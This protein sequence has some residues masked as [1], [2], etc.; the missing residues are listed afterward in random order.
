M[1]CTY[2]I[3]EI[4]S[5]VGGELQVSGISPEYPISGIFT[6]SRS[7][8]QT[9]N[10]LFIALRGARNDGHLFVPGLAE[11]GV[12][13]FLISSFSGSFPSESVAFIHVQDTLEALQRLAAFHRLRFS[14]PVIGITGSNGK[15]VI[16]EWLH[17]LLSEQFDIVRSPRSYNSQVGV[18]LSVWLMQPE[19]NLA[20]FE[21]G[22][23]RPGEMGRLAEI[24]R[25]EIGIF[26]NIG[27]AH[28][29]NFTSLRQK[30]DEKLLLFTHSRILI[31]CA[32]QPEVSV[33]A[34]QFCQDR[35]IRP[36]CWSGQGNP[37]NVQYVLHSG[38][39]G[40]QLIMKTTSGSM[41]FELP[42]ADPSSVE[43][44][45]HALALISVL[46]LN[47]L[48]FRDKLKNLEPLSMRLELKRGSNGCLLLNDYYNSDINS[49][50]IAL[51]VL[52]HHARSGGM[53]KRVILSDIRQSGFRQ[54]EL[55]SRVNRLLLNAGVTALT[56][57]G[58]KISESASCFELDKEFFPT[59]SLYLAE[60]K[61]R[62]L[63]NEAILLKGARDFRL[64]E[65]ASF[66]QQK[67]HQTVL[68]INLNALVDNL[69]SYR[70]LLKPGTR[71][72]VMVK[73][74]SY[75]SGDVEIARVL[76][77]HHADYLAVAVTDEGK[78]LRDAGIT[79][80][81]I[82][83][84]PEPHSF[85]T[86][87]DYGLEP[88]L[89]S[90][91][92]AEEFA[93]VAD[94]NGVNEYPVHLKLDTGMNRLGL[95]N[96]DDLVA[97]SSLLRRFPLLKLRS[98]FSHL[99][100][101]DDPQ[102]DGFTLDQIRRFEAMCARIKGLLGYPVWKHIL[103][104]AGIERFPEYQFD[105]VRL[106][107]GLYGVSSSG[108]ALSPV[109]RLRSTIS[110]I[111]EVLPGETVGYNRSGKVARNSRIAIIPVGYAD[112]LDRRMGNGQACILVGNQKA[113]VIGNICM[114][115]FMADVTGIDCH[116]GD[117]IEI[118][119]SEINVQQVAKAIGTIPYELLTGISQRVK[120]IYI[121]E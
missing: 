56:G 120:R 23:S 45:C 64:E 110:Q 41:T 95:K 94:L 34:G 92:L 118:F 61:K 72:M 74:F 85:Q 84:N 42:L 93:R 48:D 116:P 105:M 19:N 31:Y 38:A 7:M 20:L 30:T 5:V 43:N 33:A 17:D 63:Q 83:M 21:A 76:Q 114:D 15:T 70:S 97:F 55:Y 53:K 106:G 89:Y 40:P 68:E 73:A 69:N 12:K 96:E 25:P 91:T 109:G 27:D 57:I 52:N 102:M 66:L 44:I 16:K 28:Q 59:T 9:E 113:P 13:V 2:S 87:I 67:Q 50:E 24:I 71:V 14:F 81:V 107:I 29:E 32:D 26:S 78:D 47:P 4:A 75:G 77:L 103:N 62:V 22:I 82:V 37:A 98:V 86:M 119:G 46:G 11:K 112:G 111:K 115:M 121:Q 88:N 39:S 54:D 35:G 51:S 49:L 1:I 60:I 79:V 36:F 108:I 100:A 58:P 99:A 65:I 80:P 18:P 90:L 101:S 117:E 3:A 104:S 10:S 8:F 6:D